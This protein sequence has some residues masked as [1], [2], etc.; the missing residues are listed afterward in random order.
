MAECHHDKYWTTVYENCMACR[1]EAAEARAD[2]LAGEVARKDEA[3]RP[4]AEATEGGDFAKRINLEHLMNA[5]RALSP[6]PSWLD[7]QKAKV[8]EEAAKKRC[9]LCDDGTPTEMRKYSSG[10]S[11]L[12]HRVGWRFSGN[13]M[14]PEM[15]AEAAAVRGGK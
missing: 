12:E 15:L 9:A 4:F 14:A 8:W 3:L 11:I 10:K 6:D 5:K 13:C 7:E 2:K 1:A